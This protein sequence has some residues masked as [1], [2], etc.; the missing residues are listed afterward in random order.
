MT[1]YYR[2][3]SWNSSPQPNEETI[4]Q[5]NFFA[6][7]SNWRIVQLPNGFFQTECQDIRDEDKWVDVTRRSSMEDAEDAIDESIAH[8]VYKLESTKGPKVVKTFVKDA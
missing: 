6:T 5:W 7:K 3:H 2:T 8:Y 4:E 1:F